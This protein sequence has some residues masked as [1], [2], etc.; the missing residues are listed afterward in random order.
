MRETIRT[1]GRLGEEIRRRSDTETDCLVNHTRYTPVEKENSVERA[2]SV[3]QH[4]GY[5]DLWIPRGERP[6]DQES[7]QIR[8]MLVAARV[9]ASFKTQNYGLYFQAEGRWGMALK[10]SL[11][12]PRGCF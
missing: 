3:R 11:A 6:T 1:L 8:G 9:S 4:G 2:L 7:L 5:R 12:P 10:N